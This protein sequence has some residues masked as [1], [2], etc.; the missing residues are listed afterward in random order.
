MKEILASPGKI[1]KVDD[2]DYGYLNQFSWRARKDGKTYYAYRRFQKDGK[3]HQIAMHRKILNTPKG[4]QVNHLD[5]NGLNNQRLNI[6]NCDAS[7]NCQYVKPRSNTGYLGVSQH[8]NK[9]TNG[10]LHIYY[11][12]DIQKDHKVFRLYHGKD[13]EVA[14]RAYDAKAK[15]LFGEFANVNF[16]SI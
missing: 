15:E 16:K 8:T 14:A 7:A 13:A 10:T 3:I 2:A 9:S 4:V 12:A 5:W 1:V 6:I 11:T